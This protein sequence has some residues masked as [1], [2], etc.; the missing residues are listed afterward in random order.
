[1]PIVYEKDNCCLYVTP[2]TKLAANFEDR[3]EIWY[4]WE[5]LC[6]SVPTKVGTSLPKTYLYSHIGKSIG[7]TEDF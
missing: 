2:A 1:M 5:E 3:K 4:K 7:K 6:Y